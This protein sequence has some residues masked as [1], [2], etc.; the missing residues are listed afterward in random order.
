[1]REHVSYL[2]SLLA[3]KEEASEVHGAVQWLLKAY[4]DYRNRVANNRIGYK[5]FKEEFHV[6]LRMPISLDEDATYSDLLQEATDRDKVKHILE[7]RK[8]TEEY[9]RSP[10]FEEADAIKMI[11]AYNCIGTK[12]KE[13]LSDGILPITNYPQEAVNGLVEII[14]KHKLLTPAIT[15]EDFVLLLTTGR[16]TCKYMIPPYTYNVDFGLVLYMLLTAGALASNWCSVICKPGMLITR[17]GTKMMRKNLSA[18]VHTHD[19]YKRFQLSEKQKE[20]ETDVLRVL[21]EVP[22]AIINLRK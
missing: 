9:F 16:P 13:N 7:V 14:H 8:F 11:V 10:V 6:R 22:S 15:A 21:S 19:G 20:I 5:A 4:E 3:S 2:L 17:N 1:M 12:D 18:I